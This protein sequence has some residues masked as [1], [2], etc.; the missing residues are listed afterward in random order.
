MNLNFEVEIRSLSK[1]LSSIEMTASAGTINP[2]KQVTFG[3]TSYEI[4]NLETRQDNF[5]MK[6][7]ELHGFGGHED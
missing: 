4:R 6:F 1:S 5:T 3:Y 7:D 2:M